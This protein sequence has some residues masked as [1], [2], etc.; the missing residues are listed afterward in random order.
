MIAGLVA[1]SACSSSSPFG[2]GYSDAGRYR[3]E[4]STASSCSGNESKSTISTEDNQYWYK[5]D[6]HP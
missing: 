1:L 3:P 5:D 4:C 2:G 6:E